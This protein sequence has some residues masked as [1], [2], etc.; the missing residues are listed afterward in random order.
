[1]KLWKTFQK[2]V[3]HQRRVCQSALHKS[4]KEVKVPDYVRERLIVDQARKL[5][6]CP[7]PKAGSSN[8]KRIFVKLLNPEFEETED[9]LDIRGVHH[10]ELPTLSSFSASEQ[11]TFLS[12]FGKIL[13]LERHCVR[14]M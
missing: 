14:V 3:D 5:I 1:M 7:I 12:T 11:A 10:I 8:W 2:R 13:T 4:Q 9:L 6:Y